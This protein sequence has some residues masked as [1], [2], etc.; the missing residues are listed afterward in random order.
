MWGFLIRKTNSGYSVVGD[1]HLGVPPE[2]ERS[3]LAGVIFIRGWLAPSSKPY[4]A[5]NSWER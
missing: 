3:Q 2:G 5:E 4:S 1:A